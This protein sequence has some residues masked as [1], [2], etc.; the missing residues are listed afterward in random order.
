MAGR[1]AAQI[2]AAKKNLEKARAA[3]AAK[4]RAAA[5]KARVGANKAKAYKAYSDK[6][7]NGSRKPNV[8]VKDPGPMQGGISKKSRDIVA[9]ENARHQA[10]TN[11]IAAASGGTSRWITGTQAKKQKKR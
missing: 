2:A 7:I 11:S 1:S 3:R 9:R 4:G 10:G 5:Q 6:H 8:T